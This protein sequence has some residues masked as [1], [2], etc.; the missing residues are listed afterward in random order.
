MAETESTTTESGGA[1]GGS[2]ATRTAVKAVA[3]A[4][5][6]GAAA[7]AAK[8]AFSSRSNGSTNG[9]SKSGDSQSL[10]SSI[11]SGSW[12]AAREALVPLAADAADAAGKYLAQSGPD[13][14]KEEIVPRF[15]EAF[16]KAS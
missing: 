8:K 3:A 2:S 5:A 12:D 7:V 6:T 9:E 1:G 14:V 10:V 13:V 15:I 4:A 11:A 16:N